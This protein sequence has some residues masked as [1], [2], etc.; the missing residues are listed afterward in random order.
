MKI[1][2][3][4]KGDERGIL[5]LD[6]LLETHPWN[7]RNKKNWFWKYK[8]SNPFGKSIVVVAEN[9]KRI[10]ATFA[11]IPIDYNLNKKLIN[12]S[13]SIAMLVHPDWQKRRY[14]TCG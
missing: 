3:Y 4:K 13:H 11:I 14:Q 10:V 5:K 1:R 8:G 12:G 9:K 2:L 6:S 7:R